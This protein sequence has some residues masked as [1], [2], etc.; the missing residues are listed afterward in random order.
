MVGKRCI[1]L[2]GCT[3]EIRGIERWTKKSKAQT[4]EPDHVPGESLPV[5]QAL[6]AKMRK[7]MKGTLDVFLLLG[8]LFSCHNQVKFQILPEEYPD[9]PIDLPI[10]KDLNLWPSVTLLINGEKVRLHVD[11][12]HESAAITLTKE[13]IERVKLRRLN[14]ARSTMNAYG[15]KCLLHSYVA[16]EIVINGNRFTNCKLMEMPSAE[17]KFADIGLMG[18][19]FLQLFTVYFDLE[20]DLIILYPRGHYDQIELENWHPIHLDRQNRFKARLSGY[21]RVFNVGFDTGAIYI[22]GK[23][24][25]NWIRVADRKLL[26]DF[27]SHVEYDF[28]VLRSDLIT[29][30]GTKIDDLLFLIYE[31]PEPDNVDIFLGYDFFSKYEVIVD[32]SASVLYYK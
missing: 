13:Q 32:Y 26:T 28:N 14:K 18:M 6:H 23:K 10:V 22:N 5:M 7:I 3:K 17:D 30:E 16:D 29:S 4:H 20:N 2:R 25:Y 12:G 21:E 27:S 24:G 31:T 11:N 19:G 9:K 15:E 1:R 8:L